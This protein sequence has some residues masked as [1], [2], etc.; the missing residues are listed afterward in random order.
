RIYFKPIGLL[1]TGLPVYEISY[2][3]GSPGLVA[4]NVWGK[5]GISQDGTRMAM[6]RVDVSSNREFLTLKNLVDGTEETAYTAYVPEHLFLYV[7]PSF[8]PDGDRV[9]FLKRPAGDGRSAISLL[10]R[11]TGEVTELKTT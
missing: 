11:T 7:A 3:G 8:S 4:E 6:F 9:A 2:F 5:F 10:D 1:R